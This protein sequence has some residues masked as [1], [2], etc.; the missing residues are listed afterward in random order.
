VH[1]LCHSCSV[2]HH[3]QQ[4]RIGSELGKK[5]HIAMSTGMSL[6]S[7]ENIYQYEFRNLEVG[8]EE[9]AHFLHV[10]KGA[11]EYYR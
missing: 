8:R 7:I 5:I 3:C 1:T 9:I 10:T 11:C 2:Y 6:D 4:C